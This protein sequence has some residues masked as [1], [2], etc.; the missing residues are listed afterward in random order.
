VEVLKKGLRFSVNYPLKLWSSRD[1][2]GLKENYW[3]FH[4]NQYFYP[5]ENPETYM[6]YTNKTSKKTSIKTPICH[7]LSYLKKPI[8]MV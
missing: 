2:P 5:K 6:Q 8:L 4:L 3:P 7:M 1:K